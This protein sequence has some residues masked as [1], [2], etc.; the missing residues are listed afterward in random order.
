[1]AKRNGGDQNGLF[2]VL[3]KQIVFHCLL[4][5]LEKYCLYS[6]LLV[7]IVSHLFFVNKIYKKII[8]I[9][10]EELEDVEDEEI[11]S[12]AYEK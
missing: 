11:K 12:F 6:I 9:I 8:H 10:F 7:P 3:F 1:M 4:Y 2:F 5:I